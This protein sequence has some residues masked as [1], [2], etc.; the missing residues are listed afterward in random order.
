M[1]L[2]H[3][4]PLSHFMNVEISQD[5]LT[6]RLQFIHEDTGFHCTANELEE[7]LHQHGVKYGIHRDVLAHIAKEKDKYIY[8]QVTVATGTPPQDGKDGYIKYLFDVEG[9]RKPAVREDGTVNFKEVLNL[10]NVRKGQLIA[11]RVPATAGKEGMSVTGQPIPAK[12]GKETRFKLGKNVVCDAEKLRL[13]AA[14]DGLISITD[15]DKINVFPVYEVN[16]DVDYNVGNIDFVGTVVIRG[17]VLS[18]FRVKASGDI[19]VIGGVEGAEL[20]ADGSI[21]ITAGI[22]GTNK[23]IVKAKKNVR[24]SFIQDGNVEAGEDIYVSQSIMHSRIRAGRNVICQG[25]KGLIVGGVIQAGQQ[26]TARVIGNTTSTLTTIEVGVQPELRNELTELRAKVKEL[27]DNADKTDKALMLLDQLA[28]TG[29]LSQ[30]KLAM[31]IRLNSTKRQ[32][33]SELAEIRERILEIEKSLDDTSL[34]K[35][36]VI[37]TIYPG[38]KIVIGRYTRFIK[39]PTKHVTFKMI[40]GEIGMVSN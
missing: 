12:A 1:D 28:S 11:E 16:G 19:R 27:M 6:A 8:N 18:G 4:V 17:N 38:C 20:Y 31:R 21:E 2:N 35:V 22:L 5:R 29:Q 40:D 10:N 13:Y 26:V 34:S 36:E 32:T 7:F 14:I 24:S 9:E 37:H 23:G 30:D 33:A 25:S 39:D 3:G 15:K